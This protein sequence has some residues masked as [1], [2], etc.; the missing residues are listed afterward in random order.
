MNI[1]RARRILAKWVHEDEHGNV[2]MPELVVRLT[3]NGFIYDTPH[4]FNAEE[5]TALAVW[6]REATKSPSGSAG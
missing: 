1:D 6:V 3:S 4:H 5:A 2:T